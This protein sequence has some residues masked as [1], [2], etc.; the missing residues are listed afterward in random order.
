MKAAE[1]GQFIQE[2]GHVA[3]SGWLLEKHQALN[4]G[5]DELGFLI[6]ALFQQQ[7]DQR[8]LTGQAQ[9]QG[10]S[11]PGDQA[12]PEQEEPGTNPWLGR[13]LD[14]GWAKWRGE[15]AKRQIVFDPLWQRLYEL[16]E[17]EEKE[18]ER[19]E[20]PQN[21][22]KNDFDY[23][24]IVKELDRLR[25]SLS[26]TAREKQLI[27][28]FNIKYGWSTDFILNF[29]RLCSQRDLGQMKNYKPLAAQIYR[30]GI[31]TL[32]GLAS[33]MNEVDWIGR[34]AAE[35]KKDYLGLYGMVTVM[36]RDFYVKWHVAWGLSHGL[37]LRAARES[38]G[39]ANATFKY[40]DSILESWHEQGIN[41]LEA[42]EEAIRLWKEEKKAAAKGSKGQDS[43]K[44]GKS[45]RRQAE[46][47][48]GSSL[49]SGYEE[50]DEHR[51]NEG[52]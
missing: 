52:A 11:C 50:D 44:T 34:K 29:F 27:Q 13:A 16:W 19:Q 26:I 2:K 5:P 17:E 36:E 32:E 3:V 12:Y 39:A 25:G 51:R 1:F 40:I 45:N 21:A 10:Q 24:R 48:R 18:K 35:I 14:K 4:I 33:F 49:W 23:C 42:C 30:S 37:I 9:G 6:L 31:Y 15:G 47:E 8:A 43:P 20:R 22:G 38:V 7:Q 41:S 28:E 46:K